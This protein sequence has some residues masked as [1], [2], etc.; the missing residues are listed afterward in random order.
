MQICEVNI[1]YYTYFTAPEVLVSHP[2]GHTAD[3]W[4]LGVLMFVMLAGKVCHIFL[5]STQQHL[6]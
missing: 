4:S 6:S 5:I 2:Y 1:E 3:W